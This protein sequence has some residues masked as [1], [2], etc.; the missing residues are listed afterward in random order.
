MR[1]WGFPGRLECKPEA[2][3]APYEAAA[4]SVRRLCF[5][6]TRGSVTMRAVLYATVAKTEASAQLGTMLGSELKV[7]DGPDALA[8]EMPECEAL[9]IGDMLYVG[10]GAAAV[11]ENGRKLKWVQL[12]TAGYDNTK[13]FG[14]PNRAQVTNVGNALAPSVGVHAVSLLLTLQRQIP[15]FLKNQEKHGWD[16]SAA[17]KM[18]TPVGQ[19]CAVLGFGHIGREIARIMRA[20]GSHVV[21]VSR[22]GAPDTGA[23]E[24]A[25]FAALDNVIARA[26]SIMIALPLDEQTHHLFDARLLGLCKKNAIIVNIARGGIIDQTALT[27]ALTNGQ[28]GGA[29]LDALDPEPFPPT[30]PLWDAPHRISPARRAR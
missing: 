19:T 7:V 2:T 27:D 12:L 26:D 13:E 15:A 29:G 20:F 11:I 23:D 9:F 4:F 18:I 22:N 5:D 21:G 16:R 28:I 8:R 17:A 10:D 3:F 25:P 24:M 6:R 30:H 14:V 1:A